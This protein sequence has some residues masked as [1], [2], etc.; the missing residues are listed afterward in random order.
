MRCQRERGI[1]NTFHSHPE[2]VTLAGAVQVEG[3]ALVLPFIHLHDRVYVQGAVARG[4][5]R[6]RREV[7]TL[8]VEDPPDGYSSIICEAGQDQAVPF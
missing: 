4:Q 3:L 8:A 7:Q 2:G 6:P 5:A 1:T